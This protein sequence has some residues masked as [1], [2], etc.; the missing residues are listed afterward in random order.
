ASRWRAKSPDALCAVLP[1]DNTTKKFTCLQISRQ[2]AQKC[3]SIRKNTGEISM[4]SAEKSDN[5][6][7]VQA[8]CSITLDFFTK[9]RYTISKAISPLK[10]YRFYRDFCE[11]SISHE[12]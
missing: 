10:Q 7:S 2:T 6:S 12:K 1:L 4:Q 11:R 3:L 5:L 8:F 9:S